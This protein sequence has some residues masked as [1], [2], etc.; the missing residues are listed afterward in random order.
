MLGRGR[1]RLWLA[2][3]V[4]V[5][6]LAATAALAANALV[7][8]A[9]GSVTLRPGQAGAV[10][11]PYPDALEYGNAIYRDTV[12]KMDLPGGHG[13]RPDLAKVEILSS[14]SILGGSEYEVKARDGNAAGTAPVRVT[15]VT[16][17]IEPLPH[18]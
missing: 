4:A 16:T 9:R 17:T 15:V 5:A 7:K 13:R 1:G 12:T 10:R 3:T 8:H 2:A 14:H 18:S 6:L 11:V